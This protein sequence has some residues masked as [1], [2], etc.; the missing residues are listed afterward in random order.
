LNYSQDGL[1]SN[2]FGNAVD[3]SSNAKARADV[4][5]KVASLTTFNNWV[6]AI[7]ERVGGFFVIRDTTFRK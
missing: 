4:E 6:D 7:V 3:L 5:G 1:G 2:F